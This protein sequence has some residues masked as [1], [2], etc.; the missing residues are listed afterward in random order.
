M[1]LITAILV[2]PVNGTLKRNDNKYVAGSMLQKKQTITTITL[3]E[4]HKFSGCKFLGF[5]SHTVVSFCSCENTLRRFLLIHSFCKSDEY[6][7]YKRHS[8][9]H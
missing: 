1:T 2:K 5:S 7:N 4:K 6:F 8:S 3:P 9:G